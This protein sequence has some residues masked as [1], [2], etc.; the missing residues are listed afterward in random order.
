MIRHCT[1]PTCTNGTFTAPNKRGRPPS[2]C[3]AECKATATQH[4]NRRCI[5][6]HEIY[7]LDAYDHQ[8][9]CSETCRNNRMDILRQTPCLTCDE[10]TRPGA[11]FCSPECTL[12]NETGPKVCRNCKRGITPAMI[13]KPYDRV[14]KY[15]GPA[16]RSA[17]TGFGESGAIQ[18]RKALA[19]MD[20][21]NLQPESRNPPTFGHLRPFLA[22]TSEEAGPMTTDHWSVRTVNGVAW[23]NHYLTTIAHEVPYEWRAAYIAYIGSRGFAGGACPTLVE[24]WPWLTTAAMH[25]LETRLVLRYWTWCAAAHTLTPP[26]A[27]AKAT[28]LIARMPDSTDLRSRHEAFLKKVK[29][30]F[31]SMRE[32]QPALWLPRPLLEYE[33]LMH[34]RQYEDNEKFVKGLKRKKPRWASVPY[35]DI[36]K[37][38]TTMEMDILHDYQERYGAVLR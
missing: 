16:C 15:C 28:Q 26:A 20:E 37:K 23:W 31:M 19:T 5:T 25:N 4:R 32:P 14:P 13:P 27:Q 17:H 38:P 8:T 21:A 18:W 22:V 6:C 2:F 10:V 30:L 24:C 35:T 3:S 36:P 7:S 29:D 34:A 33:P 1:N 11:R 12:T 9:F